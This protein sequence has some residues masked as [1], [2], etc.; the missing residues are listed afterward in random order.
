MAIPHAQSGQIISLL[1][2]DDARTQTLVK[3]STLEV[4][5][6]VLPAGKEIR[7]HQAK[8]DITVQCLAGRVD[9][10]V[11]GESRDLKPGAFLYLDAGAPHALKTLDDSVLL[12]TIALVPQSP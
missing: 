9:F 3:T 5:R 1:E 10:Q 7:E 12:L 4:I 8:G 2:A 11:A 6:M